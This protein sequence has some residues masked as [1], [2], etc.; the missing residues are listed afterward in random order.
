[1]NINKTLCVNDV[2]V[3]FNP[4]KVDPGVRFPLDA[5]SFNVFIALNEIMILCYLRISGSDLEAVA[6]S[7]S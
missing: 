7:H 3:T 2:V 5:F 4:S 1:M 6:T